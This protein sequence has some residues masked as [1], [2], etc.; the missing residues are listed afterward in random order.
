VLA[1]RELKCFFKI[2]TD[3]ITYTNAL[4]EMMQA[5]GFLDYSLG[6]RPRRCTVT[7]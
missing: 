1:R 5:N 6:T 7:Y 3:D 2:G 4:F